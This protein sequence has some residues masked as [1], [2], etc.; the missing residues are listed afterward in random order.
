VVMC[1]NNNEIMKE[2]DN[3]RKKKWKLKE[4]NNENDITVEENALKIMIMKM[5]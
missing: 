1:I 2:N 3:V 4:E 5:K